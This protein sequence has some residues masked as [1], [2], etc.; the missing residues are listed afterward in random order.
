MPEERV[1][2]PAPREV[3]RHEPEHAP[4]RAEKKPDRTKGTHEVVIERYGYGDDALVEGDRVSD[5]D[6]PYDLD[7]A[8]KSGAVKKVPRGE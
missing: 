8:V 5:G 6:T 7:D 2:T 1:S 3:A 4:A